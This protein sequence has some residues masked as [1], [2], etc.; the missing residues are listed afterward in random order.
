MTHCNDRGGIGR[1]QNRMHYLTVLNEAGGAQ[2]RDLIEID[3]L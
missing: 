2:V 1:D 3:N